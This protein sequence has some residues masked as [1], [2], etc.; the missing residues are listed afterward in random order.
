MAKK[1]SL[2]ERLKRR[3]E[4]LKNRGSGGDL[5]FIKAD[6]EIRVRILP[7]GEENEFIKEV[8][9]F[10]LGSDIKGVI[11]P[12][13]F[14]EPCAIMEAYE[15]LK[16]SDDDDDRELAS[17]FSPKS[18]YLAPVAVYKDLKGKQLDE[19]KTGKFVLIT[20][21]LYQ[22]ILDKYL[23]EDEWGD[24]TDPVTGYD[25]KLKRT[26]SGKMDTEYFLTPCKPTPAPKGW[27]SKVFDIDEELR[28][29]MPS[30]EETQRLVNQYLNLGSSDL[31]E[32]E[33]EKPKKPKSS[34][35][36]TSKK[37]VKKK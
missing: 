30:Y 21:G 17:Q 34:K 13:T 6:T 15:Q 18:R 9:H 4:E 1:E 5:I 8:V 29:I 35:S 7:V 24:M 11:S 3:R 26:G 23:D 25:L 28:K 33:D 20:G 10:Y 31:D 32:D 27:K 2:K 19:E 22:E 37:K 12:A 16:S 14:G 36:K